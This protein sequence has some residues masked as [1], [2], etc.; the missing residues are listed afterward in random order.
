MGKP[1]KIKLESLTGLAQYH[2]IFNGFNLLFCA[3]LKL[4]KANFGRF[5]HGDDNT[6]HDLP[7]TRQN[8]WELKENTPPQ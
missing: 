2:K 5:F 8:P 3:I 7:H 6:D 4:N 1:P